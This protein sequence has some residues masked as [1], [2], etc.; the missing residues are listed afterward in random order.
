MYKFLIIFRN[1]SHF[2]NCDEKVVPTKW[3]ASS[4]FGQVS[5]EILAT[6]LIFRKA[7]W[8]VTLAELLHRYLSWILTVVFVFGTSLSQ[9]TSSLE[10]FSVDMFISIFTLSIISLQNKVSS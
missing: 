4:D 6:E 3:L 7:K 2:L 8:I 1:H 9:G 10:H 5:S